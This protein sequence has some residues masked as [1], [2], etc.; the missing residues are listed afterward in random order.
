MQQMH[1]GFIHFAPALTVIAVGTRRYQIGP[2]MPAAHMARD[3]M[4]DGE[5]AFAL[6]AILAGIIVAAEY[7]AAR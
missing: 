2:N 3:D 1:V 7:F 6:A 5:I 4:V